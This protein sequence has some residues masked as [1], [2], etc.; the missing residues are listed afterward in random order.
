MENKTFNIEKQKKKKK[1]DVTISW[2]P[3]ETETL[4][5]HLYRRTQNQQPVKETTHAHTLF[6]EQ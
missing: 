2:K 4:V 6:Q 5:Q 3:G 1:T